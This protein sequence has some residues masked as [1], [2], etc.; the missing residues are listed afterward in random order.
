MKRVQSKVIIYLFTQ[1]FF[2]FSP[3]L[4]IFQNFQFVR[5]LFIKMPTSMRNKQKE[6]KKEQK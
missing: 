1:F 6:L 3:R 5:A 4:K 2:Q